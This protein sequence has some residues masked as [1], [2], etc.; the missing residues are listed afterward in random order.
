MSGE[1]LSYWLYLFKEGVAHA[2]SQVLNDSQSVD[3]VLQGSS[4][5]GNLSL[6]LEASDFDVQGS[7]AIAFGSLGSQVSILNLKVNVSGY[8]CE[9]GWHYQRKELLKFIL[10]TSS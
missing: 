4:V 1:E 8:I 2:S 10:E 6:A 5:H 7:H 9:Q 3:F